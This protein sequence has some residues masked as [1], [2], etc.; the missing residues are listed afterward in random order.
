MISRLHSLLKV[1][2]IAPELLGSEDVIS[3]LGRPPGGA[4]VSFR[5]GYISSWDSYCPIWSFYLPKLGRSLGCFL[6]PVGPVSTYHLGLKGMCLVSKHQTS[7]R[8]KCVCCR[9]CGCCCFCGKD[10][11]VLYIGHIY[12]YL[13]YLNIHIHNTYQYQYIHIQ[14]INQPSF[15]NHINSP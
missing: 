8:E 2:N 5:G 13:I 6:E 9:K 11:R 10:Q 3:F 4:I 12:I 7:L 14:F 15:S 1:K